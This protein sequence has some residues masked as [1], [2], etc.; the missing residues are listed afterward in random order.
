MDEISSL[1]REIEFHERFRGYDPDEVDAYVDKVR[2]MAAQVTG[3]L[4]E[5]HARAEAAE[6]RIAAGRGDSTEENLARTLLLAQRTADEL[7][8]GARAE[9]EDAVAE[10][11]GGAA[12]LVGDAE[13]RSSLI[14]AEAETDRRT[15]IAAAED[16]AAAAA[17]VARD[18]LAAEVTA[19]IDAKAFLDDDISI[20]ERHLEE[21]RSN[22]SK[23]V[24]SLSDLVDDPGTFRV[25]PA[26][27]T[28]GVDVEAMVTDSGT[29]PISEDG[30]DESLFTE[31]I[32]PETESI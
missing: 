30:P 5:L 15:T 1:S 25:S 4:S 26:P 12:V 6:A 23:V 27:A 29:A 31:L 7:V 13:E 17:V 8:E 21:Q 2:N 22:L 3:R 10:A 28:S 24:S 20:L 9:S 32:S 16:E 11:R 14:L 19:L 18:R